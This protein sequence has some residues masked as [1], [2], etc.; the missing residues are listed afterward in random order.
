MINYHRSCTH[1]HVKKIPSHLMIH[2]TAKAN[3]TAR[4]LC[5]R[6]ERRNMDDLSEVDIQSGLKQKNMESFSVIMWMVFSTLQIYDFPMG[7]EDTAISDL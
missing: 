6:L 4:C 2:F 1:Q 3:I 5:C 7:D